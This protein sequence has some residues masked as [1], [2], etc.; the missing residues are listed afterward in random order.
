MPLA[1]AREEGA[2]RMW[3]SPSLGHLHASSGWAKPPR[4]GMRLCGRAISSRRSLPSWSLLRV[5]A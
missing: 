5:W 3:L 1:S 2:V 4:E